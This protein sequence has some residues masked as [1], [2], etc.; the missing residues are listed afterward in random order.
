MF[1][2]KF[3]NKFIK[4]NYIKKTLVIKNRPTSCTQNSV[5]N[6]LAKKKLL[7]V[8]NCSSYYN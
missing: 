1:F 7:K 6:T 8:E 2:S 5:Q 4:K 3:L